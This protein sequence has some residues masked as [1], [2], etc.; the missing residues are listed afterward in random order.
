MKNRLGTLSQEIFGLTIVTY[1]FLLS[2]DLITQGLVSSFLN[3][4]LILALVVISS[5]TNLWTLQNKQ[6]LTYQEYL[7]KQIK[8]FLED[9]R[10]PS[11]KI[12]QDLLKRTSIIFSSMGIY[13]RFREVGN[14]AIIISFLSLVFLHFFLPLLTEE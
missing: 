4:N 6:N 11:N 13:L 2:I 9:W 8:F 10:T 1:L 7:E 14:I 3:L 12:Q 5:V